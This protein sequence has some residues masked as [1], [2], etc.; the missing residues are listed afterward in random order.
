MKK[1]YIFLFALTTLLT[2]FICVNP[3]KVQA[4]GEYTIKITSTSIGNENADLDNNYFEAGF[5]QNES[6]TFCAKLYHGSSEANIDGLTY[7]WMDLSTKNIVSNN[8][9]LVLRKEYS[10]SYNNVITIG[11]KNYEV[12]IIGDAIEMSIGFKFEIKDDVNHEIILTN[13]SRPLEINSDGAYILSNNSQKFTINALLAMSKVDCTINWYIKKPNSS[14]FDLLFENGDCEIDPAKLINS[15]NGFGLYKVFAAAQSSSVLFNSKMIY[16]EG[17]SGEL[18]DN[19][20]VYKILKRVINNTKSELEAYTFTLENA[21]EDGLDFN[22]ILWYVNDVKMGKGQNFS[23]EPTTS[24]P[25][26]VSVQYQGANLVKLSEMETTP[27]TTGALKLI[28][29]IL[30]GVLV[31]S[32][33]F[34][35]SVKTLNKKR[36]VVW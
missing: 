2:F 3:G 24:D 4:E 34:G 25:F 14:T 18:N 29:Y 16:F 22:K 26:V 17:M 7:S 27:K 36:D 21:L 35:I 5:S 30:G 6:L 31:L 33:I 13:I 20:S 32:T 15:E 11:E 12:K 23:Y 10:N 19:L 28:L 9:Y 1:F 8:E